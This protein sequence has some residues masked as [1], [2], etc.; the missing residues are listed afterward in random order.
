MTK[1][2]SLSFLS[3]LCLFIYRKFAIDRRPSMDPSL[4]ILFYFTLFCL[5]VHKAV[6]MSFLKRILSKHQLLMKKMK[7]H[8][9]RILI[10]YVYV[11]VSRCALQARLG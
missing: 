5:F 9:L 1:I 6:G 8:V 7:F 10:L 2:F 3:L 4:F 11:A